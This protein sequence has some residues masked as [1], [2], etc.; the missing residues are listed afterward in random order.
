MIHCCN[1]CT[2]SPN[3]RSLGR[4][5]MKRNMRKPIPAIMR[6]GTVKDRPQLC[7]MGRVKFFRQVISL[8]VYILHCI[9]CIS[10]CGICIS[11][12]WTNA[13]AMRL[14][15][16][17]P[18]LVWLFQKPII[19]P[20][21]NKMMTNADLDCDDTVSGDILSDVPS[22]HADLSPVSLLTSPQCQF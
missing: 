2:S 19:K 13:P 5:T 11:A 6:P 7:C 16:M 9:Y 14:P 20:L 17:F 8:I 21:A 3:P 4:G 22:V 12:T 18:R 10:S 15:R 1:F